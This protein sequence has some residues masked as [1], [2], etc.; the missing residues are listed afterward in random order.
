MFNF[1]I[2]GVY[3]FDVYP[4]ALMGTSFKNV[5]ILAIMDADSANREVDTQ[6]LHVQA[7]P[8]LPIGTPND[9][10]G[11][12]YIKIK[13]TAGET[14]ILGLA[15]INDATVTQVSHST[16]NVAIGGV[17]ASDVSKVRNA[18]IQNGY[19]DLAISIV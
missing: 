11:Y 13:T 6:A 2:R 3:S 10:R 18:L 15:W 5:T 8:T 7:Y 14:T 16:I 1:Q 19:N 12:D 17:S 9:P 4:A